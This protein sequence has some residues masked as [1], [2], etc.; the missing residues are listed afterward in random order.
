M[1]DICNSAQEISQLS[2][3]EMREAVDSGFDPFSASLVDQSTIDQW[4]NGLYG[5]IYG[6]PGDFETK[7]FTPAYEA[8]LSNWRRD[9]VETD[10]STWRFCADCG[11]EIRQFTLPVYAVTKSAE[12]ARAEHTVSQIVSGVSSSTEASPRRPKWWQFWK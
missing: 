12:E 1:C 11:S 5:Q 4:S 6:S 2:A 8:A 3:R 10:S 7:D 9:L